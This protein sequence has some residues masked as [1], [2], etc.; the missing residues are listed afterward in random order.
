MPPDP[1]LILTLGLESRA[2][3]T[4]DAL[5]RQHFPPERNLLAAHLTLFHA[6]PPEHARAIGARLRSV[7]SATP[8]PRLRFAQPRWLGRGVAI[9]VEAPE[10]AQL[11]GQLAAAWAPWL[12][13][14]DRQGY[15]PH[16]TIQNKVPPEQARRLHAELAASW[17]P[18]ESVGAGLLLWRYLGGPWEPAGE[19]AFAGEP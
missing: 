4:L 16:V 8:A 18:F 15:R 17:V 1:P 2:F 11:R 3:D 13:P 19:F 10:L 12:T 9:D 14:Q 6:L 5:R 7:A